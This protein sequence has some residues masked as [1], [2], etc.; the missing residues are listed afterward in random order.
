MVT[1]P[2]DVVR[3]KTFVVD[4][5][6]PEVNKRKYEVVLGRVRLRIELILK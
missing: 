6:G 3:C 1:S 2:S 5:K 4:G